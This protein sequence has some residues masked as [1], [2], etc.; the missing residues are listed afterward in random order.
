MVSRKDVTQEDI[1]RVVGI[2]VSG[3]NKILN[4]VPGPVFRQT[5]KTAV[6]KAAARLGYIEPVRGKKR[7]MQAVRGLLSACARAIVDLREGRIKAAQATL[8]TAMA[9]WRD[10]LSPPKA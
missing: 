9:Q 8:D 10:M 4:E 3:V 7:M 2:D 5:T 1:A 6:F